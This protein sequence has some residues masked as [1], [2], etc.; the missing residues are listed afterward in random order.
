[1]EEGGGQI[2]DA[3]SQMNAKRIVVDSITAYALLFNDEYKRREKVLEFFTLLS[4]WGITAIIIAEEALRTISF[5]IE[6]YILI[7]V[8]A[9]S[10]MISLMRDGN[11]NKSILYLP[12]L[13]LIAFALYYVGMLGS[14]FIVGSV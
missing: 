3:L 9:T 13:L 11:I 2:R 1:L 12:I 7:Q 10:L 6:I 8:I 5:S 4:K 14:A